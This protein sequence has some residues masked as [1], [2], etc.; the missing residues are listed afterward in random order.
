MYIHKNLQESIHIKRRQMI[1]LAYEKGFTHEETVKCSQELDD[2][3]NLYRN[4]LLTGQGQHWKL[5]NH[6][7]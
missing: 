1:D 6:Y 3:L 4:Y 2:L 7:I 5:L